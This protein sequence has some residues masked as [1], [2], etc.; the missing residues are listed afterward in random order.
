LVV[1]KIR[2]QLI[3][4]NRSVTVDSTA[5]PKYTGHTLIRIA[6]LLR[7]IGYIIPINYIIT[8]NIIYKLNDIPS[9]LRGEYNTVEASNLF[10]PSG[11]R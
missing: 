8:L 11:V 6:N 10:I 4:R 7:P 3:K 2:Y 5:G 9:T 1:C